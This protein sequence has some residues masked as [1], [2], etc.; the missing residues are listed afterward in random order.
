M[1][2]PGDNSMNKPDNTR[3]A[4]V[5]LV[6]LPASGKSTARAQAAATGAS[7]HSYQYSTD[8]K[9]EAMAA[10]LGVSYSEA[11]ESVVK[12]ATAKANEEVEEAIRNEQGVVWDQTNMTAK[13]RRKI[14]N[15]FPNTYRKECVC[16]LPPMNREQEM[17]LKRRLDSRPGK[18]I[19]DYVMRAMRES[20]QLPSMNEGFNRVLYFDIYGNMI[21][22][23][24]AAERFGT[25]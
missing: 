13:K 17:E 21:D 24:E 22:R 1:N 2:K 11:F 19:P 5:V 12:D 4:V 3:P 15:R 25:A 9:I 8:D 14:L 23:N 16:I 18:E 7:G 10:E 20:F 6:G